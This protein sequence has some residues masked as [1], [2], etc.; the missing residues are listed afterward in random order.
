[1]IESLETRRHF[2]ATV[3]ELYP[4]FYE[5]QG[6]DEDDG[7]GIEVSMNDESF[8]LDGNTYTGLAYLYIHGAGGNDYIDVASTD[9][10]GSIGASITGDDGNDYISLNFGGGVWGGNGDDIVFLTDA[11]SGQAHGN[12]GNDE[13]YIS[14]ECL[15]AEIVGDSGDDLIDCSSN[16][17]SV[18]VSAGTG[19]DTVYGTAFNDEIYGDGGADVIYGGGGDDVFFNIDAS[20]GYVDGGDGYDLVFFSGVAP[21][22]SNVEETYEI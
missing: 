8:T 20:G 12:R 17:Y 15:N 21:G 11:F 9:G 10:A 22:S 13:I 16:Y 1:M 18:T 4:G 2:N 3:T 5:V 14:G 6:S 19:S 7:I